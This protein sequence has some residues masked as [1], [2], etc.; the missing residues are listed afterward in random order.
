[1]STAIEQAQ[2]NVLKQ[3]AL[4]VTEQAAAIVIVDQATYDRAAALVLKQIIPWRRKWAEYWDPL[5]KTSWDAHKAIVTKFNEGDEPAAAAEAALKLKLRAWDDE[6][7]TIRQQQQR[8]AQEAAERKEQEDRL[9]V[10]VAAETSGA[11]KEEVADII[12]APV[13]AV[14]QPVAPTYSR[15]A[16]L[17]TRDNWKC[18]VTDMK[19]L[20]AAV[21]KGQV[22]VEYV[23]PNF[24]ALNAR[25]RAD[26]K[27]MNIP[28]CVSRNEGT[29]SGRTK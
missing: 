1:M 5:K 23:M 8:E 21:A 9:A 25:A 20:C 24:T 26:K 10:A 15:A 12:D 7:E 17:S 6:Q 29:M 13:Q 4:T 22:S 27:T 11:T 3:E 28:G 2:E 14:A 19:K 18:V 16:G